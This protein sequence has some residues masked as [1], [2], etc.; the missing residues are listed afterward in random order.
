MIFLIHKEGKKVL[1]VLK[2][3]KA[4]S[5]NDHLCNTFLDLSRRFP[6]ELLIWVEEKHRI[7]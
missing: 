2:E 6:K 3:G 1:K 4:I 5:F 7:L